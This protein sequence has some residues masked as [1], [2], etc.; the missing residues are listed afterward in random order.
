MTDS[1]NAGAAAPIPPAVARRAAEWLVELQAADADGGSALQR[2][3]REWRAAH[4]DHER[5][6]QQIEHFGARIQQ[7]SSPLAH[8]T[9][10]SSAPPRRRRQVVGGVALLL[11]GAVAG[12][13]W[14]DKPWQRWTADHCTGVGERRQLTLAD[15]TRVTLN[16][17]SAIRVDV[18][19][20]RRSLCL[21]EGEI[22]VESVV[23]ATPFEVRTEHGRVR[24][25]ATRFSVRRWSAASQISVFDGVVKLCRRGAAAVQL[26]AGEQTCI[27]AAGIHPPLA[28]AAGAGA[29]VNGML[30][31]DDM[32]LADFLAELGRYRRGLLDCDAAVAELRISGT[33]PLADSEQVLALLQTTLPVEVRAFTRYWVQLRARAAPG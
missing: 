13:A 11:G 8:A 20:E 16:S 24:A 22:L 17:S 10:V 27:D 14:Q 1:D 12:L 19:R 25:Q 9:L 29:W 15:G 4:P 30:V 2:R 6:W 21:L 7:L 26:R 31:A 3:W 18:D 28:L 33:Y 5:A 23:G 32:R